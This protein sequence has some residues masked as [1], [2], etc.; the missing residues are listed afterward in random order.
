M[1]KLVLMDRGEKVLTQ[2][3]FDADKNEMGH[4]TLRE[5]AHLA[6]FIEQLQEALDK[7]KEVDERSC[8]SCNKKVTH[9][10]DG[11]VAWVA[12]KDKEDTV[13]YCNN[14]QC[15]VDVRHCCDLDV[16]AGSKCPNC[17]EKAE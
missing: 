14:E 11:G 17:G 6:A 15:S 16:V 5:P 8:Y 1:P 9:V 7:D 4:L 13:F 12:Y 2:W 3:M 10:N